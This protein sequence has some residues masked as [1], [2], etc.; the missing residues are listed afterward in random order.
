[1]SPRYSS[2][3]QSLER[4]LMEA[5]MAEYHQ[6]IVAGHCNPST[7]MTLPPVPYANARTTSSAPS[8][9]F[10]PASY[11]SEWPT[12]QPSAS[13]QQ[14]ETVT[15]D[16]IPH[17]M[18]VA[19]IQAL[20]EDKLPTWDTPYIVTLSSRLANDVIKLGG[21]GHLGSY[22]VSS[23]EDIFMV[24]GHEGPRHYMALAVHAP[25]SM[26]ILLQGQSNYM[27]GAD[28]LKDSE[29]MEWL[30]QGF[31]SNALKEWQKITDAAMRKARQ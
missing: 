4:R 11:A 13:V 25:N 6:L 29:K 21:R 20:L 18:I 12:T 14:S 5:I 27:D 22:G 31:N 17:D 10:G 19:R 30:R 23:V 15:T 9:T 2:P 8:L 16:S 7:H 28:P 1:M 3:E 24:I 26:R